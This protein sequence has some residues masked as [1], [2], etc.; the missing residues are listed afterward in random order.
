MEKKKSRKVL[1][2]ILIIVSVIVVLFLIHTIR[3]F[4]IIKNLQSKIG[5]YLQ[6]TNYHV[7]YTTTENSNVVLNS[8]YYKKDGKEVFIIERINNNQ[9][10]K[11]S[12]YNTGERIDVFYDSPTGKTAQLN[13]ETMMSSSIINYFQTESNWQILIA[14]VISKIKSTE[15]NGKAC[16]ALVLGTSFSSNSEE[17][18]FDK[19]TGLLVK[20]ITQNNVLEKEYEFDNVNDEVFIEPNIG[21]YQINN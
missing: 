5:Q 19:D 6:S 2:I 9:S 4:I 7:K 11:I 3:N 12:S 13:S 1:K 14:G 21:E 18:Y 16:Y 17:H 20:S 8:N 15:H 10:T